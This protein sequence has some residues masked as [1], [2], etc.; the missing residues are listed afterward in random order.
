ML[1]ECAQN[2]TARKLGGLHSVCAKTGTVGDKS[3]NTDA[4]CI[5]YSPDYTV[6]VWIGTKNADNKHYI[7]G[8]GLP[9]A[10]ANDVFRKYVKT[11]G[12][13]FNTPNT[14]I[15][16]EINS[17][18]LNTNHKIIAANDETPPKY[19]KKAYFT[20]A[21]AP[22]SRENPR[23]YYEFDKDKISVDFDNFEII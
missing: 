22:R 13:K 8:G 3:G 23:N 19:R 17:D 15:E 21:T 6:A 18:E 1:A 20:K 9:T 4:Y 2:G 16:T 10:I 12:S 7:N 14:I 11:Y 5:A